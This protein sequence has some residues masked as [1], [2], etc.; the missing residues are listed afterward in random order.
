MTDVLAAPGEVATAAYPHLFSPITVGGMRLKN[1]IVM[2]PMETKLCHADGSVSRELIAYYRERALGGVAMVV[3]EYTCVDPIDGFSTGVPQLR[4]DSPWYKPGHAR[5]AL[6]VQQAGARACVQLSH[7]GRQSTEKVLGLQPIAPSATHLKMFNTTPRAMDEDDIQ[8]V[9]KSFAKAAAL[10]VE[11]GYDAVM[12]HGAHGYLLSQFMSPLVNRRDDAWGGDRDRRM[13][14]PLEVIKAVRAAIGSIPLFYRMSV[15]DFLD[16]GL[17]VEDSEVITPHM[18]AAGVDCIDISIAS[19][20]R[21]DLLVEGMG[22]AEGWRLPMAERIRKA[23]GRPVQTAGVIRWPA[24]A[25]AAIRDGQTDIISL[26]RALLADPLW[27]QK[28]RAGQDDQIRPCTSCNWCTLSIRRGRGVACAENP[29]CARELDPPIGRFGQKRDAVVVGAGP[30]GMA[31]A[32]MLDKAGYRVELF[33]RREALGGGLTV[34]AAPPNKEKLYW[35]RDYLVRRIGES[36]ITVSIGAEA[37]VEALAARKPAVVI[38]ATGGALRPLQGCVVDG[39]VFAATEILTGE[40]PI[41]QS[42]PA[43]PVVVYGGGETGAETADF[44]AQAGVDVVLITRSARAQ[45]ARNAEARHREALLKRIA[46]SDRIRV[47]EHAA[48]TRVGDGFVEWR[49][50]AGAEVAQPAAM[51]LLAHGFEPVPH[52]AEALQA[53]GVDAHPIGDARTVARI[54]EAVHDAYA[55]VQALEARAAGDGLGC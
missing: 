28:A 43:S 34:S 41:P 32:L 9:I 4:L 21:H 7:A 18:I 6:A 42:S 29:R 3:V 15:S 25:E 16:G 35:Y 20:D 38:V 31:A 45:L 24:M 49:D 51:V 33:E 44:L 30:A 14:F 52:L 1:R 19:L 39:P 13:R 47:V 10:A 27:P 17:T 46:A 5:L 53:R 50:Q 36:D 12:L 26:G 23:S 22:M 2:S 8:R 48:L 37:D 55:V 40:W 11:C 54:G